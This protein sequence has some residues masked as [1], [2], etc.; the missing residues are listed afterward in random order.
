MGWP[1]VHDKAECGRGLERQRVPESP[2]PSLTLVL[3]LSCPMQKT[4][5]GAVRR[6]LSHGRW[7]ARRQGFCPSAST[8]L[9]GREEGSPQPST[10]AAPA[11]PGPGGRRMAWSPHGDTRTRASPQVPAHSSRNRQEPPAGCISIPALSRAQGLQLFP[12]N[13]SVHTNK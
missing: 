7:A 9:K 1:L 13:Q 8:P 10:H 4:P 6:A 11:L 2:A 12:Q 5:H 3:V